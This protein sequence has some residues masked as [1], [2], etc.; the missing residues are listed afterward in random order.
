MPVNEYIIVQQ[1]VKWGDKMAI[2]FEV[3][4]IIPASPEE[5]YD[6]W[7][8]S[9]RHAAMT[10]GTAE[11]NNREAE[12]FYAWDEYISGKNKDLH[13]PDKIVQFWRTVE[14]AETEPDSL[15]EINLRAVDGGTEIVLRHSNLPAHGEQYRSGWVENY[16]NP[17]KEYFSKS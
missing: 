10:G 3:S 17:M 13:R 6:A 16:F 2:D 1:R 7:L 15:L 5:V 8:D 14:F 9:A 12:S 11:V 4:A